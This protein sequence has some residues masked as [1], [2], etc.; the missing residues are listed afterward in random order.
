MRNL[1][2]ARVEHERVGGQLQPDDQPDRARQQLCGDVTARGVGLLDHGDGVGPRRFTGVGDDHRE[3]DRQSD[4][5]GDVEHRLQHGLVAAGRNVGNELQQPA[6]RVDDPAGDLFDLLAGRV[7]TRDRR[8]AFGLVDGQPRR[9]E[10]QRPDLDRLF[11]QR[12][13]LGQ[14][15][16]GRRLA[17]GATLTHHV[18]PQRGMRQIGGDVDVAP[19]GLQRVQVFGERLPRPGQSVGHDDAGN[20][21]DAAITSTSTSWSS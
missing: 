14:V 11:G 21:L 17:V 3:G 13:H 12:P 7:V 9:C 4:V 15:V 19:A 8:T 6:A 1:A 20:V 16:G 5:L 10:A 2:V 18:D